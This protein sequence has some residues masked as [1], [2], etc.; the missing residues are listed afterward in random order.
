M[1]DIHIGV[2]AEAERR[3]ARNAEV[4]RDVNIGRGQS[5]AEIQQQIL[6]AYEAH[7]YEPASDFSRWSRFIAA[8]T[9]RRG[10]RTARLLIETVAGIRAARR[11]HPA[12]SPA[13]DPP[14]TEQ[15]SDSDDETH[16]RS[17]LRRLGRATA[18]YGL[19]AAAFA[20]AAYFTSGILSTVLAVIAGLFAAI[21]AWMVLW[22]V[23]LSILS[24][25]ARSASQ[26]D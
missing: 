19:V 13:Q 20:A 25:V 7:G 22:Y 23:G 12:P 8:G 18:A 11:W 16:N 14:R 17:E 26:R 5:A 6:S 3:K 10:T 24:G 9:A 15:H 2:H 1:R 21:T 4:I